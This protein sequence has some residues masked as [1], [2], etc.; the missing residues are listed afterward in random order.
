[1]KQQLL[2]VVLARLPAPGRCKRRLAIAIGALAAAR[3]QAKLLAHTMA[4]A[5]AWSE[6]SV[7]SA[8]LLAMGPAQ[9]IGGLGLR[10][11]R[12]FSR[13]FNSGASRVVLI[14]S[15]LPQL[16]VSDL[17]N[18]YAHLDHCDL[19]LGPAL[20]GGYWLVG[21][22]RPNGSLFSGIGWGGAG[23]LTETIA[24][25]HCLGLNEKLLQYR[26]DIDDVGDMAPWLDE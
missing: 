11:Q 10:M 8:V 2:L 9:G 12:Q 19:V 17:A 1:M 25:A 7:N 13:A 16:S 20:D 23:V 21:L 14:G 15:D 4:T 22:N 6:I 3:V 18:A 26:S 5:Q 24:R